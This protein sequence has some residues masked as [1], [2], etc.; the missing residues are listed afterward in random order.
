[1]LRR[2]ARVALVFAIVAGISVTPA[3]ADGP[4]LYEC[5][6]H[7]HV[8][9]KRQCPE[10]QGGDGFPGQYPGAGGGSDEGGLLGTI[11]GVLHGL[12]GGIL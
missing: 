10:F 9:D 2:L 1:M 7:S 3:S 8:Y 11:R 6:N 4:T 5:L 12:T